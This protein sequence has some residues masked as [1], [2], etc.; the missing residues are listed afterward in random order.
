MTVGKEAPVLGSTEGCPG[1]LAAKEREPQRGE[2]GSGLAEAKKSQAFWR[3][4][5]IWFVI[6]W[7]MA[8]PIPTPMVTAAAATEVAMAVAEIEEGDNPLDL[9]G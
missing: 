8:K 6:L 3:K 1:L 5:S 9:G 4:G 7:E 2:E